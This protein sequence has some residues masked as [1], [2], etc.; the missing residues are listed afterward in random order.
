[1]PMLMSLVLIG[2]VLSVAN[3]VANVSYPFTA[4]RSTSDLFCSYECNFCRGYMTHTRAAQIRYCD[5]QLC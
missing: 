1:M 5:H 3:S 2:L 4:C